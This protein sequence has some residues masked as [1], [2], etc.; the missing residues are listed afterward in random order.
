MKKKYRSDV[1]ESVHA[2]IEGFYKIGLVDK[3]TMEKY[4]DMCLIPEDSFSP[5]EIHQIRK[6]RS[7]SLPM[8]AN[9]LNVS[10]SLVADWEKGT[11]KPD[12]AA[13][14]LLGAIKRNGVGTLYE[15]VNDK[16]KT[17]SKKRRTAKKKELEEV[18]KD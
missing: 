7:L 14:R 10:K 17:A 12:G 11:K 1:S 2:T 13:M 18:G 6:E 5:E 9:H 16:K 4:D 8:F 15:S 3:A